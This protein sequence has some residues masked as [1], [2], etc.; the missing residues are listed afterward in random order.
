M[1]DG[2]REGGWMMWPILL[3]GLCAVGTG[4]KFA[5]SGE[6]R[7]L[8]FL[9]ATSTCTVL[10]GVFGTTIGWMRVLSFVAKALGH[11]PAAPD[12]FVGWAPTVLLAVGTREALNC[13][14]ASLMFA[15]LAALLAAVGLKRFPGI[16]GADCGLSG[17]TG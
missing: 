4:V 14:A 7:L 12:T 16:P 6:H 9:R 17:A 13:L 8:G 11:D 10:C 2:F 5:L 1:I 3:L 15:A